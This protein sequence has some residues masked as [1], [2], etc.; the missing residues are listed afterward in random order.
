VTAGFLEAHMPEWLTKDLASY[1]AQVEYPLSVRSSSLLEDAMFQ[2]YAGLYQTYMI[3]NNHPDPSVRLKHLL[4]A[5]KLVY[6]STYYEGPKAFSRSVSNQPQLEAMGVIIQ[7]LTG[8][9]YG[10]F[11]YPAL[12]GVAQSHNFYPVSPMKSDEGIAL[13]ALGLGKTVVEGERALRFCP[14]YPNVLPQFSTVDDILTNA[15]RFFYA[16]RIR[17][18]PEELRFG[19]YYNLE[20]RE[21]DEAETES[22][23]RM[24]KSTYVPEEH[25]IRDVGAAQGYPVLAFA[26]VL[27]HGLF[28]LPQIL[29]D[30][31]ELGREGMGCPIE[32]EFSVNLGENKEQ[33][34]EFYFL[35]IRPMVADEQLYDIQ[36]SAEEKKRAFCRSSQSLGNGK[37]ETIADIV[38]VKPEDFRAE[39]TLQMA[40]EISRINATLQKEGRPYLLVGPGRWGSADRWLGIPVQWKNISGVRAMVELRNDKIRADASQG[41]HFFQNI[42]SL[43]I[44]YITVT[45]DS[46]STDYFD[47]HWVGSL[48]VMRETTFLRHVQL[49]KPFT[50]KIDGKSSEC[51]M[52][53]NSC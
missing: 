39:A 26:P 30:F 52:V 17:D 32:I 25:R 3:P 29:T 50:L 27:K 10:D 33:K 19:K 22:P 37:T 41:S 8:K 51:V 42:T 14:K 28:P 40:D 48:P 23:V 18:Y 35:Q 5:I 34:G 31:L 20:R 36:I 21:V 4:T 6:A 24:L 45:E 49:E 44:H 16:L 38:Y 11:F 47:W 7:Q 43:G 9:A 2:P 12:S 53:A 46:G 15:Q 13:I 1:L